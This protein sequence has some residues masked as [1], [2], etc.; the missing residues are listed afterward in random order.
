MNF[1]KKYELTN[2]IQIRLIGESNVINKDNYEQ[3]V[4]YKPIVCEDSL[5]DLG[6]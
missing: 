2:S 3:S 4:I 5:G 1:K 6:V